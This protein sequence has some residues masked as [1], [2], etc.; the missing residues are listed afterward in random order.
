MALVTWDMSY[1]VAVKVCDAEHQK[2]F[3]LFNTLHEAMKTGQHNTV[4]IGIVHE[5]EK[6]T[7]THFIA[8]EDLLQKTQYPKLDEHRWQHRK[9]VDQ[10]KRFRD[11]LEKD[12][13]AN[14][15]SVLIFLKDWLAEHIKHTDRMYSEHLN[16]R[17]ID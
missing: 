15:I 17:G 12:G 16:S 8:E 4:I 6:Y 2:L 13:M 1:S 7:Q 9:F 14:S 5:L 3:H 10:V 11:D